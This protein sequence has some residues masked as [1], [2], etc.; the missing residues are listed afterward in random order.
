[1][2]IRLKLKKLF[3]HDKLKI[4]NDTI[5][6]KAYVFNFLPLLVSRCFLA[7]L[8]KKLKEKSLCDLCDSSEAGGESISKQKLTH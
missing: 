5:A 8:S 7:G 1:M 4:A 2:T 3:L 6:Q